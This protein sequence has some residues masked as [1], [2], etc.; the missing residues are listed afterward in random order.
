[1]GH[2]PEI[3]G[4]IGGPADFMIFTKTGISP[5]FRIHSENIRSYGANM[6][7]YPAYANKSIEQVKTNALNISH[8]TCGCAPVAVDLATNIS[9]LGLYCLD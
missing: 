4:S 7:W 2:T 3:V 9:G 1:M 8:M 6:H 5:Y